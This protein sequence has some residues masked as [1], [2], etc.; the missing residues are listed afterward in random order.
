VTEGSPDLGPHGIGVR[1]LGWILLVSSLITLALTLFQLFLDYR[2]DVELIEGR[3]AEIERGYLDSIALGLWNVDG[4]QLRLQLEGLLRLPD[5]QALEIREDGGVA[6]RPLAVSV[7]TFKGHAAIRREFPVV[8]RERGEARRIGILTVEATL[9]GVYERLIDKALV[10][11]VSQGV[12]TFLVSLFILY[13][14]YRLVTRHL[15]TIVRFLDRYE[16]REEPV[17]P[18]V[19]ARRP[20]P[21]GDELERVVTALN[22]VH[23]RLEDAWRDQRKAL[24]ALTRG[25][26]E[27]KRYAYVASHDL[28]EPLR[29]ISLYTQR[30]KRELEGK[31]DGPTAEYLELVGDSG[32]RMHSLIRDL[33]THS[34]IEE[35]STAFEPV[36]LG[37]ACHSAQQSLWES[38][39]ETKARIDVGALPT[40]PADRLQVMQLFQNLLSNALK[41]HQPDAA[42][43]IVVKAEE[44]DGEWVVSVSDDGIGIEDSSQDVFQIFRRLHT[45]QAYPGTGVGLAISKRIVERHGGRIWLE[46]KPGRG[47]TVFFTLGRRAA[48]SLPATGLSAGRGLAL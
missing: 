18:L 22:A 38:I 33:L 3:L 47:T 42:P 9:E 11:L 29:I 36:S 8:H 20:P 40:L 24:D 16:I 35:A 32:R 10:I 37:D 39:L 13:I 30:L 48:D 2:R 17:P 34:S 43:R 31:V 23:R 1:L 27:L 41:F 26:T 14:V 4:E 44:A 28:Q 21:G 12:K 19:L 15:E 46:S 25:H 45:A 7:G 5:M 6:N